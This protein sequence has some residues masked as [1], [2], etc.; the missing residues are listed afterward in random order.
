MCA[1]FRET[2]FRFETGR[3][4][5]ASYLQSYPCRSI[6]DARAT[7]NSR[8]HATGPFPV[9]HYTISRADEQQQAAA[10]FISASCILSQC[11]Q[12]STPLR[13]PP[14]PFSRFSPTTMGLAAAA[15]RPHD[16][17]FGLSSRARGG[18]QSY[19]ETFIRVICHALSSSVS[20]PTPE[21][22]RRGEEGREKDNI[23]TF[24]FRRS[25]IVPLARY[26]SQHSGG[27]GSIDSARTYK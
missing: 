14:P 21:R 16:F 4:I 17:H 8:H 12:V 13:P 24:P 7:S 26:S 27:R 11:N 3:A 18:P 5:N 20:F 23:P 2:T 1:H 19:G 25:Y 10:E 6:I 22:E 15:Q 9:G